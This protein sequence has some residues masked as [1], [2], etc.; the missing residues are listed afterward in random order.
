MFFSNMP[1]EDGQASRK[2]AKSKRDVE[3]MAETEQKH[4]IRVSAGSRMDARQ[5]E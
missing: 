3:I 1:K 4:E 5:A 2:H